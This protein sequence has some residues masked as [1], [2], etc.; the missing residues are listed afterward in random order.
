MSGLTD[1]MILAHILETGGITGLALLVDYEL[2]QRDAKYIRLEEMFKIAVNKIDKVATK[3]KQ[4]E[5]AHTDYI[6]YQNTVN[7]SI[8]GALSHVSDITLDIDEYS[9]IRRLKD[10]TPSK[11]VNMGKERQLEHDKMELGS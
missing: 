6:E 2:K 7:Q 9:S 3:Q 4:T 10:L 1:P 11:F 5:K 8:A